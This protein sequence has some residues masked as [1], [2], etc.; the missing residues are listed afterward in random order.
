MQPLIVGIDPGTTTAYAIIDIN[1]EIIKVSSSKFWDFSDLLLEIIKY[2]K[3]LIVGTDKKISPNLIRKFS[4]KTGAKII[5]PEKDLTNY[6]KIKLLKIK[7]GNDHESDAL[8]SSFFAYEKLLPLI[9]KIDSFLEK[10]NKLE[11]KEQI[12]SMLMTDSGLSIKTALM[13]IEEKPFFEDRRKKRVRTGTGIITDIDENELILLREENN[14]LIKKIEKL[15]ENL[16]NPRE[17]NLKYEA[18]KLLNFKEQK[19]LFLEKQIKRLNE[20]LQI[21]KNELNTINSFLLDIRSN[22]VAKKIKN[23]GS[24]EF[25]AKSKLLKIQKDDVLLVDDSNTFSQNVIDFLKNKIN[26]IIYK[27]KPNEKLKNLGFTLVSCNS[28]E[29]R[30]IKNY[31][32]AS[33]ESLEREVRK[34]ENMI[35]LIKKYKEERRK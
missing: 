34:K 5:S 13:K 23:L 3:P 20:E 26:I 18:K 17:I 6:E 28:L 11:L 9:K 4:M 24:I 8:A 16:E 1:G 32:I 29:I 7:T 35:D 31:A 33:R 27:G 21:L 15:E 19:I 10:E 2:G 14:E 25:E 30:E 22:F 12:F